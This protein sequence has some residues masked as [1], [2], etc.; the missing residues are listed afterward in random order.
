MRA[1]PRHSSTNESGEHWPE[2]LHD[3]DEVSG[4]KG[5]EDP[6]RDGA[7]E[8]NE[9]YYRHSLVQCEDISLRSRDSG[10]DSPGESSALQ[11]SDWIQTGALCTLIGQDPLKYCTLIGSDIGASIVRFI[12]LKHSISMDLDQ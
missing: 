12:Q 3:E 4:G 7:V 6:L 11:V 8:V 2:L 1:E 10:G 5:G 9:K